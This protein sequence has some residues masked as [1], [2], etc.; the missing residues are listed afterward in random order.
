MNDLTTSASHVSSQDDLEDYRHL[1]SE[2]EQA[3]EGEVRFDAGSRA[4]YANDA[5]NYRQ[6]PIGV[7]IPKTVDDV[8][9]IHRLCHAYGV[10]ILSRGAG[11]SLSGETVNHAVVMDHSKYLDRIVDIDTANKRVTVQGGAVNDKVNQALGKYNL[12]FPPDPS[13]HEWCTIGGNIGNNS[14]G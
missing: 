8:I 12:V 7:T 13:T 4:L 10:P 5:S 11:T 14:C 3:I 1:A 9:V 6:P 2:L